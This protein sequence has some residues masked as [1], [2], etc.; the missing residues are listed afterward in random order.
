[1]I[2][3]EELRKKYIG[4]KLKTIISV[5]INNEIESAFKKI[6]QGS[7]DGIDTIN[8]LL[9]EENHY[10][11]FVDFDCDGHRSGDWFVIDLK[12]W[13]DTGGTNVLKVINSPV[14]NIEYIKEEKSNQDDDNDDGKQFLLIT[15]DEYLI[16]MGQNNCDHYYPSNFFNVQELKEAINIG[17]K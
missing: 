15:T 12:K 10:L 5:D 16:K 9:F 8:I 3:L 14:R 6:T 7:G 17:K 2:K 4:K 11:A 13:L 1:M